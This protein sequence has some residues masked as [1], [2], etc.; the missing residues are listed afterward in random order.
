MNRT[1]FRIG[2]IGTPAYTGCRPA[3]HGDICILRKRDQSQLFIA[4]YDQS[5]DCWKI[6]GVYETSINILTYKGTMCAS[7]EESDCWCY[8]S[9]IFKGLMRDPKE[10]APDTYNTC[11][12]QKD[13]TDERIR[14]LEEK[15]ECLNARTVELEQKC[16]FLKRRMEEQEERLKSNPPAKDESYTPYTPA[17]PYVPYTPYVPYEPATPY[18]A[19]PPQIWYTVKPNWVAPDYT[20]TTTCKV[21]V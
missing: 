19:W 17:S 12:E 15:C 3:H 16:E 21:P 4:S 6:T 7:F 20:I 13:C 11:T 10:Y 18:P 5:D 9:D 1:S 14:A 2:D 8:L